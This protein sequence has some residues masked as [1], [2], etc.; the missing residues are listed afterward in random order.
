M[1]ARPLLL[2]AGVATLAV[3]VL[4]INDERLPGHMV[5]H[6]L[7]TDLAPPLLLAG[8]PL[9]SLLRTL[10][11]RPRRCFGRGLVAVGRRANPA[12]CLAVFSVAI[13]GIHVPPVFDAAAHHETLHVLEHGAFVLAG[14]V[15]WWPLLGAPNPRRRLGTVAEL[16]YLTAAMLPMT[17]IGVYLDR[18]PALFYSAYGGRGAIA[19]QQQAGA[20]M[21]VAGTALMALL[22]VVAVLAAMLEAERR[23][24]A[25]ELHEVLQ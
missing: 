9:H 13:L 1:R 11:P 23:Q 25:R 14:L 16:L 4:A 7:L 24:R 3:A 20:I 17:L 8:R 21:W 18:A 22:G 19:A 5:Q 6:L 15:V 2:L 12:V 10:P